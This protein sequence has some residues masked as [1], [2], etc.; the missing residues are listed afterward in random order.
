[1]YAAMV[2]LTSTK[3][4]WARLRKLSFGSNPTRP[5]SNLRRVFEQGEREYRHDDQ[6]QWMVQIAERAKQ[7]LANQG[8]IEVRRWFPRSVR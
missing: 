4:Q 3:S 6:P 8:P 7:G 2:L 5:C 1:M